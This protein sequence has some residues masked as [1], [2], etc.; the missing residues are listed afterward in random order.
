VPV[1]TYLPAPVPAELRPWPAPHPTY[2]PVDV[3]RP[4]L[5]PEPVGTLAASVAE[6]WVTDATSDP[7][8]I[9]WAP[10]Q[11]SAVVPFLVFDGRPYNPAGRTGRCGRD[12]GRWGEN[13][14]ADPIVVT[15]AAGGRRVLLIRRDD[16]GQ[17][18][19]PGGM[20]DP[21]ET[22]P[23][24][25][26]RELQEETGLDLAR[27]IPSVLDRV[28]VDDP[29]ATDHAWIVSTVALFEVPAALDATAASDALDAQWF[30]FGSLDELDQA[31]SDQGDELYP[32]HWPLVRLALDYLAA[33]AAR[34]T[35]Y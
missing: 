10:R 21:G 32:A 7:T 30:P 29:R 16:C 22:A 31:L 25:L 35:P 23:A 15:P 17:W 26:V 4:Y 20:V 34:T 33:I 19:I 28:L 27:S 2:Q 1:Y 14:A 5:L 24:A 18:A 11:A 3:T 8:T 6:G 9:E 13:Q 12:L